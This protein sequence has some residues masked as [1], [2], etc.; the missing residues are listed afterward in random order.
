MRLLTAAGGTALGWRRS[1]INTGCYS[2]II[3]MLSHGTS[4]HILT[5]DFTCR[6]LKWPSIRS[7][8]RR[9]NCCRVLGPR[10]SDKPAR[11]RPYTASLIHSLHKCQPTLLQVLGVPQRTERCPCPQ[12][13][14]SLVGTTNKNPTDKS[15]YNF[16]W[17]WPW[18][19]VG[20]GREQGEMEKVLLD[21]EALL[22]P[23]FQGWSPKLQGQGVLDSSSPHSRPPNLTSP[24]FCRFCFLNSSS[25]L[26]HFSVSQVIISSPTWTT[27][28]TSS[29]VLWPHFPAPPTP[30]PEGSF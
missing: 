14:H 16:R 20:R 8:V 26:F 3:L 22:P 11:P 1:S 17:S 5:P 9:R 6:V 23:S 29:L 27:A 28:M 13:T 24:K 2:S 10:C 21:K 12:G 4:S 30:K 18:R 19:K 7:C 25:I 15:K